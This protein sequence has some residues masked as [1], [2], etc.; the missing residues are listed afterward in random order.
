MDFVVREARAI[1]TG[2]MAIIRFGTC[3]GLQEAV[4]PGS[5][6]VAGKG[7]VCVTR[8]PDA[9]LDD[10]ANPEPCYRVSRVVD[11]SKPLSK[12][13]CMH[14]KISSVFSSFRLTH[15]V[16]IAAWRHGEPTCGSSGDRVH[17]QVS[18]PYQDHGQ[19]RLERHRVLFLQ[20][21]RCR[22]LI[23]TGS[24]AQVHAATDVCA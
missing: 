8:N 7:S 19:G 23:Q 13:V 16:C 20:L 15:S 21:S 2:P 12:Q 24:P 11:A 22:S 1:V 14:L 17:C 3:G 9:F 18:G 6:I 4:A 10:A 5:V